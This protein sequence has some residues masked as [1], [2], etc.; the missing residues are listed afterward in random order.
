M[1]PDEPTPFSNSRD[2]YGRRLEF[3]STAVGSS[4]LDPPRF[5]PRLVRISSG[6]HVSS[7]SKPLVGPLRVARTHRWSLRGVPLCDRAAKITLSG[8]VVLVKFSP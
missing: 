5:D 8:G 2:W 4:H 1:R 6:T 3:D 7:L